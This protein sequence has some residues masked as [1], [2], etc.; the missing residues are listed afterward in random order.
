M[1]LPFILFLSI[2]MLTGCGQTVTEKVGDDPV[3]GSGNDIY[4]VQETLLKLAEQG[5][6]D[7]FAVGIDDRDIKNKKLN[8][9]L[10]QE[11]YEKCKDVILQYIQEDDVNFSIGEFELIEQ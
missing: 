7:I 5:E 6:L 10:T 9:Y 2:M 11:A 1:R 3:N 8:V 4:S